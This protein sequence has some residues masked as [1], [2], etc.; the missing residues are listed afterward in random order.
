MKPN[1]MVLEAI[2]GLPDGA[3]VREIADRLGFLAAIQRGLD[4]LDRGDGI[5]HEGV[6]QQPPVLACTRIS[7]PPADRPG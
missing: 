3:S 5:P 6:K 4:Q 1:E 2:H 7:S